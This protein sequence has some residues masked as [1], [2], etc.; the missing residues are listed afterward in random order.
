MDNFLQSGVRSRQSDQAGRKAGD[1][2]HK[3]WLAVTDYCR[4][5]RTLSTL[6]IDD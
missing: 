6:P 3:S 5:K 4:N 2:F 1:S